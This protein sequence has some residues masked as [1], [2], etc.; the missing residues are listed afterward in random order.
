ME[1]VQLALQRG[2]VHS[3]YVMIMPISV[4]FGEA[5]KWVRSRRAC[6]VQRADGPLCDPRACPASCRL[7]M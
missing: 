2:R 5:M 4:V 3:V 1:S 6:H 7:E